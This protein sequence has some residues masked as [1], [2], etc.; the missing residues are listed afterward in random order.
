MSAKASIANEWQRIWFSIRRHDWN[1]LALVPSHPA[2]DVVRVA[3]TLAE[4]GRV[5]GERPI[6]VINGTGVQLAGV[7][8]VGEAI[9]ANVARGDRVMVTVDPIIDNPS[10]IAIVQA[11]SSAL[12]VLRLG[13]AAFTDA[14]TT[15]DAVG[16]DR[17]LGS[18]VLD[19]SLKPSL[20]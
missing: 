18:I 9:A 17:F 15:L 6:I 14:Q 16:R 7:Q 10:A 12:L 8:Q 2:T 13:D 3:E 5:Q 1:S 19:K 4:T 20:K 11:A